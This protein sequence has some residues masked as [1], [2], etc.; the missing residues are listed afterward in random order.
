[1]VSEAGM[2]IYINGQLRAMNTCT[3][4]P[5]SYD[6]WWRFGGLQLGNSYP[7][8][9]IIGDIDDIGIWNR[10]LSSSE[11]N[12]LFTTCVL[13]IKQEPSDQ[14]VKIGNEAQ[15]TIEVTDTTASYQWQSDDGFGFKNL[16]NAGQYSG[17]TTP[18]LTIA[19]TASINDKQQFRCI[20]FT[21]GICRDTS[22]TV[23]LDVTS[24]FAEESQGNHIN[25][26]PNPASSGVHVSVPQQFVGSNYSIFDLTGKVL[27]KGKVETKDFEIEL[28]RL[29][30]GVYL[31]EL[32]QLK[33]YLI[34]RPKE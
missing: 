12:G 13:S 26:Y 15:F 23:K 22:E 5:D 8:N 32:S 18:T 21:S 34:Y 27:V 25:I 33:Q 14:T 20:A 11:I 31:F 24:G 7:N 19:N 29:K 30:P 10:A 2:A 6:G 3:K 9:T 16:T 28:G 17:V 4:S 1:M